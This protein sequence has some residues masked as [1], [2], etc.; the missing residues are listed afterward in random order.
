M[1]DNQKANRP[2]NEYEVD[3]KTGKTKQKEVYPLQRKREYAPG[4]ENS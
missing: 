2:P 4:S 3:L 1:N